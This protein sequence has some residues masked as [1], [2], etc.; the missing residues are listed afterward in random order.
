MLLNLRNNND[1][2]VI[3]DVLDINF[4]MKVKKCVG[5]YQ[6]KINS[7][8]ILDDTFDE[9]REAEKAMI[10]LAEARNKLEEELRDF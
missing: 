5:G 2:L 8:F 4:D 10:R 6:I 7:K 9:K 1:E 3:K